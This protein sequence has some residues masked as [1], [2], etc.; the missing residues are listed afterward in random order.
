MQNSTAV[1]LPPEPFCFSAFQSTPREKSERRPRGAPASQPRPVP[2]GPQPCFSLE[3]RQLTWRVRAGATCRDRPVSLP[4][5]WAIAGRGGWSGA[6]CD[7]SSPPL[8]APK[9]TA[10]FTLSLGA[11]TELSRPHR[12][13]R[14]R[15]P[16]AWSAAAGPSCHDATFP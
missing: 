14:H 1:G 10:L 5:R 15:S 4:L 13:R 8:P 7:G 2:A 12:T 6:E 3:K 11:G 16:P 9:P